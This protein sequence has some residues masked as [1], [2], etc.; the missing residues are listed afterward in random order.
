M[1]II[2]SDRSNFQNAASNSMPY[3][4]TIGF[5]INYVNIQQTVTVCDKG[6]CKKYRVYVKIN[7]LYCSKTRI[8]PQ[9]IAYH[10]H[11]MQLDND[12]TQLLL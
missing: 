11:N 10:N 7:T 8:N 12:L 5:T 1:D 2:Y 6:P 9:C 4:V 3:A